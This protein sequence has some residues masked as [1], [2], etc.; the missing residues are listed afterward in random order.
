MLR[1]LEYFLAQLVRSYGFLLMWFLGFGFLA[2]ILSQAE[3]IF[4]PDNGI[5]ALVIGVIGLLVCLCVGFWMLFF[6][7]KRKSL[8][9]QRLSLRERV[10][11]RNRH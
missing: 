1:F 7:P 8:S 2:L 10:K 9:E 3:A 11:A 4:G 5:E 6:K